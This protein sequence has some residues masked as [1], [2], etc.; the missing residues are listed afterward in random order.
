M[1]QQSWFAYAGPDAALTRS[2][3]SVFMVQTPLAVCLNLCLHASTVLLDKPQVMHG[4]NGAQRTH[5]GLA[6]VAK[7]VSWCGFVQVAGPAE[8]RGHSAAARG[9]GS[10][11]SEVRAQQRLNR[12]HVFEYHRIAERKVIRLLV[13]AH[14][15]HNDNMKGWNTTRQNAAEC[16]T[17]SS[18][19]RLLPT[20]VNSNCIDD[21]IATVLSLACKKY[22]HSKHSYVEQFR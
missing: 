17:T 3:L 13:I 11:S 12:V 22:K 15:S 5:C 19:P 6:F 8:Y 9:Q 1:Q 14:C 18:Q 7:P 4:R 2:L 16:H 21:V 10:F 20:A